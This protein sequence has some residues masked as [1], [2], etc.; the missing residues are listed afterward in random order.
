MTEWEKAP[1]QRIAEVESQIAERTAEIEM[2]REATA[3]AHIAAQQAHNAYTALRRELDEARA[4]LRNCHAALGGFKGPD[5]S[6]PDEIVRRNAALVSDL[7]SCAKIM[8]LIRRGSGR[9]VPA[10][11]ASAPRLWMTEEI[12]VLLCEALDRPGL[13][14]ELER[15]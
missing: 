6:I 1:Q 5:A 15:K 11:E 2:L 9:F 10:T 12:A 14:A 8:N 3:K 13:R 4:I 7:L